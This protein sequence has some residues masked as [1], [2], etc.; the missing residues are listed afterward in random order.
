M[1]HEKEN[2]NNL[3]PTELQT[4]AW[5]GV[6]RFAGSILVLSVAFKNIGLDFTPVMQALTANISY[7]MKQKQNVV[8]P[9][10]CIFNYDVDNRLKQ[11]EILAHE[12]N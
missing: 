6:L 2:P 9:P 8:E 3:D 7:E 12:S 4:H 1:P 10:Q 5:S 11:L